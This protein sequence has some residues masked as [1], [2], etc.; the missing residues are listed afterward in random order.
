M[1]RLLI[2]ATLLATPASAQIMGRQT[3]SGSQNQSTPQ[4]SMA[5]QPPVA[6]T[7]GGAATHSP[8]QPMANQNDSLAEKSQT[9]QPGNAHDSK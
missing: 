9:N 4:P 1:I 2:A 6:H 7:E 8:T 5:Q 3:G